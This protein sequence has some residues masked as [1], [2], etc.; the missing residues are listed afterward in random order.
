MKDPAQMT[1]DERRAFLKDQLAAIM[2]DPSLSPADR[3]R[4]KVNLLEAHRSLIE[5]EIISWKAQTSELEDFY[6]QTAT[7][8][9]DFKEQLRQMDG[10]QQ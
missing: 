7:Y 1:P 4:A 10:T 5:G 6:W 2:R 8:I 9:A 3:L